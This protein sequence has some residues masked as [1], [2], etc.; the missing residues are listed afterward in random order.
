MSKNRKGVNPSI[1]GD[2]APQRPSLG[3]RQISDEPKL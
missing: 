3:S 1:K 2:A